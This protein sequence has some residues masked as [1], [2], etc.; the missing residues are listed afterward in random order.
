MQT[1][2]I[3]A[4]LSNW[5]VYIKKDYKKEIIS[6]IEKDIINQ[7]K[8]NY[9]KN[10]SLVNTNFEI[11]KLLIEAQGGEERAQY[12]NKLIATWSKELTKKYGKGYSEKNLKRMRKFYIEYKDNQKGS[13]VLTELTWTN[14]CLL[15]SIKDIN[16]RNYYINIS[17]KNNLSSRELQ[18][19]I[20]SNAFER[21]SLADKNNIKL[22]TKE[23]DIDFT[24][25]FKNPFIIFA[26]V[27]EE[28]MDEKTL[29]QILLEK[30]EKIVLELG[31][32]FS[33]IGSEVRLGNHRC[34][35][36]FFNIEHNCYVV[37]ELKTRKLEHVDIGQIKY[38]VEYINKNIKK[39]RHNNTIGIIM[40]KY[41]DYYV[42]EYCT[43]KNIYETTY[44]I[45]N[46]DQKLLN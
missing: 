9:Y 34:D 6:L 23:E 27:D 4:N 22:V 8:Y 12:G 26:N 14:I 40:T 41:N 10:E 30:I 15:L 11:G 39:E 24:D 20:K 46:K 36:L 18:Q 38:Y 29:K 42:M 32:G 31:V 3:Y 17:V 43:D 13:S 35:L 44:K 2:F 21:L 28:N 25:T 37:I 1:I 7:R 16:K 33:F 5:R 45:I 19:E